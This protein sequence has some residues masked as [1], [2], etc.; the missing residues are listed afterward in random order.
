MARVLLFSPAQIPPKVGTA[1]LQYAADRLSKDSPGTPTMTKPTDA[2]RQDMLPSRPEDWTFVAVGGCVADAALQ[3]IADCGFK[4]ATANDLAEVENHIWDGRVVLLADTTWLSAH[5]Q[6]IHSLL[7]RN[8]ASISSTL[9]V[10]MCERGDLSL[11]AQARQIGARLWLEKPLDIPRLLAELAGLAWLPRAPYRVLL[12][13]DDELVLNIHE[14]WL[15]EAGCQVLALSDP[16]EAVQAVADFAPEVC[17]FDVEMPACR[18]TDLTAML[19]REA[20]YA[21][22][23]ILFHT[24]WDDLQHQLDAR[25]AG[26]EDYLVKP[27]DARLLNAAVIA[28]ARRFR[29]YRLEQ[30]ESG[31]PPAASLPGAGPRTL[32][33]QARPDIPIEIRSG[34]MRKS[35]A[36]ARVKRQEQMLGQINQIVLD[37]LIDAHR[38]TALTQLLEVALHHADCPRG[39]LARLE[40]GRTSRILA[41]EGWA[42]EDIGAH[43]APCIDTLNTMTGD[44]AIILNEAQAT[45]AE[46][47]SLLCLP[48]RHGGTD[49]GML[50]L[51]DRPGGF[52]ASLGDE[53]TPL[54]KAISGVLMAGRSHTDTID[55]DS[56]VT[57][58]STDSGQHCI[59]VAEDDRTIRTVLRVQLQSLG[60]D[61]TLATDGREAFDLWQQ[62]HYDLVLTDRHMPNMDGL[63]LAQAIRNAEDERGGHVPIIAVSAFDNPADKTACLDAGMDDIL[64]KPIDIERLHHALDYWLTANDGDDLNAAPILDREQLLHVVGKGGLARMQELIAMFT[65]TAQGDLEDYRGKLAAQDWT[66]LAA[67]MHKTKSSARMVGALRYAAIAARLETVARACREDET[68]T[69]LQQ[70][71][72]ALNDVKTAAHTDLPHE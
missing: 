36:L 48:L 33:I 19:R 37:Y 62:G 34:I 28:R 18:G 3:H 29:L 15:E 31:Q 32:P 41:C 56:A 23:P 65:Q 68:L 27:V 20:C 55:I 5:A 38:N 54:V 30:I 67:S 11:I 12:V 72:A 44:I 47:Q 45:L 57:H 8:D 50:V 71:D 13:D 60:Y 69:L 43:L 53:L 63:A 64:A 66:G 61:C 70:L 52:D 51:A 59:L 21:Q 16:L 49:M 7:P 17:V 14:L 22:L 40:A 35:R 1:K 6:H 24:A 9:L 10:A 2:V 39:F 42:Q 58:D 25:L 46:C 26:G 4:T